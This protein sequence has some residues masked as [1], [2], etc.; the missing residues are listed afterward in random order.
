M[1][2]RRE[3]VSQIQPTFMDG[4]ADLVVEIVSHDSV[5]RDY[6]EKLAEYQAAGVPEYW[7]VD[8]RR[9]EARFYE[10]GDDGTYHL[11]PI[12]EGGIYASKVVEGFRLR[13][14]WLWQRPLPTID[15]A[16]ADLPE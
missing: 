11:G 1:F 15:D 16:L 12:E 8:P 3:R 5:T 9:S 7:I 6:R 10:L 14:S 2:V 13:V 4:P